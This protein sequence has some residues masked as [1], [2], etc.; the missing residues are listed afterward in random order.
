MTSST[1]E[2]RVTIER[3][4]RYGRLIVGG[5]VL[6]AVVMVVVSLV[7]PV[8]PQAEYTLG[9]IVGLMALYG[10]AGG[11][12]LGALVSLGLAAIA[13]R[14]HVEAT[15]EHDTVRSHDHVDAATEPDAAQTEMT[16]ESAK[17]DLG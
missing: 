7:F 8:L 14:R 1:Q 13:R 6:G 2:E 16:E 11:L 9:Q 10:A 17:S 12:C 4:V 5:A 15:V 3:S